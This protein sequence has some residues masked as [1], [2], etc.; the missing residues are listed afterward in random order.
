MISDEMLEAFPKALQ[1][2]QLES[3]PGHIAIH[4]PQSILVIADHIL[5]VPHLWGRSQH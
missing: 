4:L 1:L 2:H 5:N 3:K